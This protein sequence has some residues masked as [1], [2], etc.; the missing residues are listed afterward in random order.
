MTDDMAC[1]EL[2]ELLTDYLDD[3]LDPTT[4]R[5]IDAHLARC[6]GCT[7]ALEQLRETV[8]ITGTLTPEHLA[9]PEREALR[10]VFVRW[11]E[12]SLS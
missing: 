7:R 2:I 1:R 4:R 5:A 6:D 10:A 12:G 8:R 11:R 9:S 3:A